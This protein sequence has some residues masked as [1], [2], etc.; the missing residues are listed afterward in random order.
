[1]II[2]HVAY[3][4]ARLPAQQAGQAKWSRPAPLDTPLMM[5]S[6]RHSNEQSYSAASLESP[7]DISMPTVGL[8]KVKYM[9]K[10]VKNT[11][12]RT[13]AHVQETHA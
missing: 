7:A 3:A 6:C 5:Y 13:K 1:M 2:K 10:Q 9:S 4:C 11:R 12:T 8:P